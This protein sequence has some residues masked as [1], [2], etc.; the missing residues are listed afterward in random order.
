[1]NLKKIR[2]EKGLSVP[3]LVEL[4]GVDVYKRQ[5]KTLEKMRGKN[6]TP[7]GEQEMTSE[8]H[9]P[10]KKKVLESADYLGVLSVCQSCQDDMGLGI[11]IGK[12]G[13]GK[14]YALKQYAK[15]PRVAYMECDDTM[16][17]RDLV[18]ALEMGLGMPKATSGTIWKRVNRIRAVSYTHLEV[19]KRQV[20]YCTD[21]REPVNRRPLQH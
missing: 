10:E 20:L 16:S 13:Y 19:Y 1:M 4:S 18:D 7:A 12:S 21:R 15:M 14:T 8:K 6:G 9:F 2:I 11:I 3:A 17:C 5:V